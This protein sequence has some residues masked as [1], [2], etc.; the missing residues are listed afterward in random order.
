MV[1]I[2]RPFLDLDFV[3]G[4]VGK[5]VEFRNWLGKRLPLHLALDATIIWNAH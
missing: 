5:G 1:T 3:G 4:I 2:G